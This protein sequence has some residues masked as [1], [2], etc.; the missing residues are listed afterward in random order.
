MTVI[1]PNIFER[2]PSLGYVN[3]ICNHR[4][5]S[6][7]LDSNGINVFSRGKFNL[8]DLYIRGHRIGELR[9]NM[10]SAIQGLQQ[11][12]LFNN[13]I[14]TV[15]QNTFRGHNILKRLSLA[16]NYIKDVHPSLFDGLHELISVSLDSNRLQHVP[17]LFKTNPKLEEVFLHKNHIRTIDQNLLNTLPKIKT[18]HLYGNI[19]ID[20]NVSAD[21]MKHKRAAKN[22][23][24]A[25]CNGKYVVDGLRTVEII[26]GADQIKKLEQEIVKMKKEI[27]ERE[28][29]LKKKSKKSFAKYKVQCK[30][31]DEDEE[32]EELLHEIKTLERYKKQYMN[33]AGKKPKKRQ[34]DEVLEDELLDDEAPNGNLTMHDKYAQLSEQNRRL[35]EANSQ[36]FLRVRETA[37]AL[38]GKVCQLSE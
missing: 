33:S 23:R 13:Q 35:R 16:K 32:V 22:A 2:F 1:P 20:D 25:L 24:I 14:R 30:N 28:S 4:T 34:N 26:S 31:E 6:T 21:D 12:Y 37:D 29:S 17:N 15:D 5:A 27:S 36:L 8:V 19:C 3:V 38:M 18:L 11:L 9:A 7:C 10:F